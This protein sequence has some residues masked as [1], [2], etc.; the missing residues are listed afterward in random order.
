MAALLPDAGDA[1]NE[2]HAVD[3]GNGVLERFGP[4]DVAEQS[5][6]R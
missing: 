3:V 4:V 6:A 2:A 5:V 1:W